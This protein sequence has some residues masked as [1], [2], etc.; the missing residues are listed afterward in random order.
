MNALAERR[1]REL[2]HLALAEIE[3]DPNQPRQ[4]FPEDKLEELARSIEVSAPGS[5]E[6]WLDGLLH[7][8]VVYPHPGFV[9]GTAGPRYRLL[10]GERRWRAYK[11]RGW[12]VIPARILPAP[13]GPFQALVMQL[14]ENL[15]RDNT[16][17][18]E[19]AQAAEQ[20][21]KLW[22]FEHNSGTAREFAQALGRSPAWVSQRLAVARAVGPTKQALTEGHIQSFE[23]FRGFFALPS[24]EQIEALNRARRSTEPITLGAL[25]P[26]LARLRDEQ[27][28]GQARSSRAP[29]NDNPNPPDAPSTPEVVLARSGLPP[30]PGFL[31][32]LELSVAAGRALLFALAAP[33]PAD[34]R[35]LEGALR[36]VITKL[37]S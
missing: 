7:P 36:D 13:E 19:D 11:L 30:P 31:I 28:A 35:E 6:P 4:L 5:R 1:P 9:E 25:R 34:D 32:C 23:A 29:A 37:A 27:R 8:I 33:V 10:A 18:W 21:W 14:H 17:L 20:A 16:S 12:P 2:A 22:R 15:G 3:R 24:Q 26:I